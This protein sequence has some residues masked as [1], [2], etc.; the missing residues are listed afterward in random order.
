MSKKKTILDLEKEDVKNYFLKSERY[1]NAELPLYFSFD[2]IL[3]KCSKELEGK[4]VNDFFA[5]KKKPEN[6]DD[7][8]YKL[9]NNKDGKYAWRL[10]ELIHPVLYVSL[11]HKIIEEWCHIKERFEKWQ[12]IKNIECKS[13]PI[14]EQDENKNEKAT[15][16]LNWWHSIEQES[17]KLSIEYDYVFH[18][19]IVDCYGAIYTHSIPWALHGKDTAKKERQNKD[20]IGNIIDHHI[21]MMRYGQTNG[22]PQGSALMDFIAEMVLGYVDELLSD[23]IQKIKDFK[24]LR[25][26]DDYR[27][28]T[29]NVVDGKQILKELSSVLSELGMRL[30]TEKTLFSE[31]IVESAVKKDKLFSMRYINTNNSLAKQIL[32]AKEI[33]NKYPNSGALTKEIQFITKKIDKVIENKKE[34]K[35]KEVLIALVVDLMY[36]KPRIY[37]HCSQII[38]SLLSIFNDRE[39]KITIGKIKQKFEKVP[40]TEILNLFLQRITY[41]VDKNIEYEG[42]LCN[43]VVKKTENIVWNNEWLKNLQNFMDDIVDRDK[44]K[45]M[46]VTM[47]TDET[48]MFNEWYN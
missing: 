21:R 23:K 36:R 34:I 6:Y 41:K 19:D 35:N 39:K 31:D 40:N 24:I 16:I 4:K 44:V 7:V 45:E 13:I 27:I 11:V 8:N 47:G 12:K 37:P 10:L 17:I 46:P 22:I 2:N 32:I 33:A 29:N 42:K 26:R 48:E 30:G 1:C 15:Q 14:I 20:L 43:E 25:Y 5:D 9:F 3:R 38:S 18:T 28:F